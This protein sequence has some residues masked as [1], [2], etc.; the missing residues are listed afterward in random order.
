MSLFS[1]AFFILIVST[2]NVSV[3]IPSSFLQ[4]FDILSNLLGIFNQV[5]YSIHRG[6][7]IIILHPMLRGYFVS[8][9]FTFVLYVN[10][11]H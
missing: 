9:K 3:I 1:P 11:F 5:F 7:T 10:F 6:Q 8:V 2:H 4:V